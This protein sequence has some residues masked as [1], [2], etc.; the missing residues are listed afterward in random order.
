MKALVLYGGKGTRLK[1][2][3]TTMAK[4]LFPAA[5]KPILVYALDQII[6]AAGLNTPVTLI[7]SAEYPQKARRPN[8]TV[9]DNYQLRLLGIADMRSWQEALKDYMKRRGGS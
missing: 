2:L 5:N 7:T 4:Q 8:N 6:A 1:P 3:T 9:L